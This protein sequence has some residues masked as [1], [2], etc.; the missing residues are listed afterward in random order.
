VYIY[1]AGYQ[2]VQNGSDRVSVRDKEN[3]VGA[4]KTRTRFKNFS[5][6]LHDLAYSPGLKHKIGLKRKLLR[7]RNSRGIKKRRRTTGTSD[8]LKKTT[9]AT[10]NDKQKDFT[11]SLAEYQRSTGL[12]EQCWKSRTAFM[13][14]FDIDHYP[15]SR[16]A[17]ST[18][19]KWLIYP[20]QSDK[21]VR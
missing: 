16:E 18:L 9:L 6:K 11:E 7:Q 2:C 3:I 19:V 5:I 20:V 17:A 10:A 8:K 14:V 15:D 4:G 12:L 13:E 21:F 1:I